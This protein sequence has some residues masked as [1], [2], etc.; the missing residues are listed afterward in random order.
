MFRSSASNLQD[1]IHID[2]STFNHVHGDWNHYQIAGDVYT[3]DGERGLLALSKAA[4]LDALHD[5]SARFPPPKCHPE[6]R[7][8]VRSILM[9]W[10]KDP[11]P[12]AYIIWMYGPAGAGKSSIAQT[13]AE[14]C[15]KF[16]NHLAGTF[17]FLRGQAGREAGSRLFCTLAYQLALYVPGLREHVNRAMRIDPALP[18]KDL[19]TQFR[20]LI[21][22][23]F[24]RLSSPPKDLP[25]VI[26]DGLD[27]CQGFET[28]KHI[29][30][31][32][33]EAL[34]KYK[35]PLRFL[36]ASRPEP[37]I[38]EIFD[39]S[40]LNQKTRRIILDGSFHPDRDIRLF[41]E[42]GFSVIAKRHQELMANIE[43][44][45]PSPSVIDFLVQKSSGQFIYAATVLKFVD[46][47]LHIPTVQLEMVLQP[48]PVRS[49]LFSSLDQL[50]TQVLKVCPYPEILTRIFALM[51]VLHC[52]QP[53]AVYEDILDL[54][55]GHVSCILR[56]VH[57]LVRFPGDMDD[58][59]ERISLN[60]RE[61]YD[62]TCGLRLH[63]ASFRDFLLDRS[64][65]DQFF[66]DSTLAHA[67]VIQSA[68]DLFLGC[69]DSS[70]SKERRGRV[71]S[72]GTWGYFKHHFAIHFYQCPESERRN[73]MDGLQ[74]F[75]DEFKFSV[76]YGTPE[77]LNNLAFESLHALLTALVKTEFYATPQEPHSS[78]PNLPLATHPDYTMDVPIDHLNFQRRTHL[79]AS[80]NTFQA[81]SPGRSR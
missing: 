81:S 69:I 22:E 19:D 12:I 1:E 15:R 3:D 55:P 51:L 6:T 62:H 34:E 25:F 29:L 2:R 64:R 54:P 5:A 4:S 59:Q 50:Y 52:P 42:D 74:R 30:K 61:K 77:D 14:W 67:Q 23:P 36:I 11:S 32:I 72:L 68:S 80:S 49:T 24:Q 13:I 26:I 33:G 57:S 39:T 46:A 70:W 66:V 10:I 63:H 47:E 71:P 16:N 17:F 45:W 37:H 73:V 48:P 21:I 7:T 56:G 79:P 9:S 78:W 60:Q 8:E 75:H 41:L 65:S 43:L 53:I 38:R 18:N 35:L 20:T 58:T 76:K 28:Q 40:H 27:E 44:P 31:L